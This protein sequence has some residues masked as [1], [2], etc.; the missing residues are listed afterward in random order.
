MTYL[1]HHNTYLISCCY[2][3]VSTSSH[4][5][6]GRPKIRFEDCSDRSKRRKSLELSKLHSTSQLSYTA[7]TSLRKDG[8]ED[9]A[10]LINEITLTTP[11][12]AK[13]IRTSWERQKKYKNPSLMSTEEAL[14]II[15]TASLSKFQYNIL[16]SNA[17]KHNHELYPSYTQVL[18]AKIDS[19]PDGIII[20]EEKCEVTKKNYLY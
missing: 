5:D 13:K 18:A 1:T 7:S 10:K 14:S 16:R 17:K 19:Y 3:L 6:R 12:R 9:A 11:T 15:I 8:K 20:T 4:N 2:S